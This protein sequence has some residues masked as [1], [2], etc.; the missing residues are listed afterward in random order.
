MDFVPD[1]LR[2]QTLALLH[3]GDFWTDDAVIPADLELK[4]FPGSY[5]RSVLAILAANCELID[6]YLD[7]TLDKQGDESSRKIRKV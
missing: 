7:E 3:R 4:A 1:R 2:Y 5:I 6:K